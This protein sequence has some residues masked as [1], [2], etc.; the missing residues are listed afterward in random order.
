MTGFLL[1][2]VANAQGEARVHVVVPGQTLGGIARRY[3]VSTA[4]L[5]RTNHMRPGDIL[6]V[7]KRLVIPDRVSAS[8][9]PGAPA[10]VRARYSV[11]GGDTLGSI[12][13]RHRVSISSL[14]RANGIR[15]TDVLRVGQSLLIPPAENRRDDASAEATAAAASPGLQ[16]LEVPGAGPVYYFE[17][18]G[19]RRLGLAPVIMYLHGRGGDPARDCRRWAPIARSFGWLVCPGGAGY[20]AGGRTWNNDWPAGSLVVTKSLRALRDRYGRRV[21]LYGNTLIG[22]SEGAFVAMNVGVR[23]PRTFNRWLILGASDGYLGPG[24][25]S[26]LA[27]GRSSLHRVVLLTGVHDSVVHETRRAGV[28][29]EQSGVSLRVVTPATLAHEVAL[30]REASLYRD[31]LVWLA[32]G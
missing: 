6:P 23:A 20:Y 1:G 27:K 5:A 14:A 28:W 4:E 7:G 22:F 9:N 16:T 8:T 12:A 30:E 17:P 3:D 2:L 32:G 11:V 15:E 31:A 24:G 21:Q 13:L 25:P 18:V 10:G 29:V 26:L 19:R